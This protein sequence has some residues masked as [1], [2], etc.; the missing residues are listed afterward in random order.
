MIS[1]T[2]VIL[3]ITCTAYTFLFV[4]FFYFLISIPSACQILFS[5][6][7]YFFLFFLFNFCLQPMEHVENTH[8]RCPAAVVNHSEQPIKIDHISQGSYLL[9]QFLMLQSIRILFVLRLAVR[10]WWILLLLR[11]SSFFY[12]CVTLLSNNCVRVYFLFYLSDVCFV[13]CII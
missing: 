2:I 8:T 13:F 5:R 3:V 11:V 12:F 10:Q 6:A 4:V 1:V 9:A 7:R